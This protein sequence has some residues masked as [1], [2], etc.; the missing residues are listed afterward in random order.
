[1][2]FTIKHSF[3]KSFCHV[4]KGCLWTISIIAILTASL[5]L[6]LWCG[7]ISLNFLKPYILTFFK[8]YGIVDLDITLDW[9]KKN[10]LALILTN[11]DS[12]TI[13]AKQ[14]KLFFPLNNPLKCRQ[15][16]GFQCN[17]TISANSTSK[18]SFPNASW[19]F[20]TAI[21]LEDCGVKIVKD[22]KSVNYSNLFLNCSKGKGTLR[23]SSQ[24]IVRFLY[25]DQQNEV[26][27]N[28]K[29]SNLF[30]PLFLIA[31]QSN[32]ILTI[33]GSIKGKFS[34]DN[35][36]VN[37]TFRQKIPVRI[38]LDD[39]SFAITNA[40]VHGYA[41]PKKTVLTKGVVQINKAL[42]TAAGEA[43]HCI[44]KTD[45]SIQAALFK[46]IIS[47]QELDSLWPSSKAVSARAWILANFHEG[48][49]DNCSIDCKFTLP[50]K[51]NPI[52]HQINGKLNIIE[53]TLSFMENINPIT[54]LAAVANFNL[55]GFAIQILSGLFENH[56][57]ERGH[58]NITPLID[59]PKLSLEIF[60]TGPFKSLVPILSSFA[61][62]GEIS[63][64]KGTDTTCVKAN[65]PLLDD[66][67]KEEVNINL[68]SSVKN[69]SFTIPL[70]EKLLQ[71]TEGTVVIAG[72]PKSIS[73]KGKSKV[74]HID[75]DWHWHEDQLDFSCA[76]NTKQIASIFDIDLSPYILSPIP[77]RGIYSST[78]TEV[79]ADF[80]NNQCQIPEIQWKKSA[81]SP[82]T[83]HLSHSKSTYNVTSSGAIVG[84]AQITTDDKKIIN[85]KLQFLTDKDWLIYR[86]DN[87]NR[88]HKLFFRGKSVVFI[89]T[90]SPESAHKTTETKK[91]ISGKDILHMDCECEKLTTK[92]V[93]LNNCQL[94]IRGH[95]LHDDLPW[96]QFSNIRW[97]DGTVFTT[98]NSK[99]SKNAG[100]LAISF[101]PEKKEETLIQ[102]NVTDLGSLLSGFGL[103]DNMKN[104]S[105]H[106]TSTQNI[107]GA[108]EGSFELY[109]FQ[110]KAHILGKLLALMS[111]TMLTDLFSSGL[112]FHSA[113]GQ[114]NYDQDQ[115]N[116][117]H[118]EGRGINLGISVQGKV[119]CKN[120]KA[121]L[122]GVIVPSYLVNTIF[123]Y[124][125]I[126]GWFLGGKNG[127]VSAEFA[128]TGTIDNPK[129]RL[130]PFSF[131]KFGFIK[132][133]FKDLQEKSSLP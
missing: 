25:A 108:Y 64:I 105:L 96:Y 111:P 23:Q 87:V 37:A 97:D 41:D 1:M 98:V 17:L 116:I 57:I 123:R 102:V 67:K 22:Q 56:K 29:I 61:S 62:F 9:P 2:K 46:G 42:F 5:T 84:Q 12:E 89:P 11:I 76:L 104:G 71:I 77:I 90:T 118:A 129:I 83:V 103:T 4:I 6:R 74:N 78:K 106:L 38:F 24:E 33:K 3:L 110:T 49:I 114:F 85:S 44:E 16:K 20:T 117:K 15:I 81:N 34:K 31:P 124:V 69:A 8:S 51:G 107:A 100:H 53:A 59:L 19:I 91:A 120:N 88:H 132:E 36:Q 21:T 82:M 54:K 92:D 18:T 125:P 113:V 32:E 79:T 95:A 127:I 130:K 128:M 126:V 48:K 131:L 121:Q 26:Q 73:V 30:L 10:Y 122:E 55:N 99:K 70:N 86:Y 133:L 47:A 72:T 40:Y 58:V 112:T 28:A 115:L 63:N 14:V 43:N 119:D 27:I 13:K 39:K 45:F 109:D 93:I 65:F 94:R 52:L 80:K 7:P 66:L 35:W 75:A 101:T 60:L 50:I 68:E